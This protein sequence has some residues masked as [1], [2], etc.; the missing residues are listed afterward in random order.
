MARSYEELLQDVA[1]AI[2][3][4]VDRGD[5]YEDIAAAAMQA[6]GV[7]ELLEQLGRLQARRERRPRQPNWRRIAVT[8][9]GRMQHHAYCETHAQHNEDCPFCKDRAAYAAYVNAERSVRPKEHGAQEE[10]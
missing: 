4:P 3:V 2:S 7:R 1:D 5:T 9:A 8:L 10:R 6:A